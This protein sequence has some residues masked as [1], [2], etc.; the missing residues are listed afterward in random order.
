MAS[1]EGDATGYGGA[2]PAYG[3]YGA[4]GYGAAGYGGYG[5]YP[6]Q[7]APQAYGGYN[8][9]GYAQQYAAPQAAYGGYGGYGGADPYGAAGPPSAHLARAAMPFDFQIQRH[10]WVREQSLF[11][12]LALCHPGLHVAAKLMCAS[13]TH[14]CV[15]E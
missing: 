15:C 6:G 4:A 1:P 8:P 9:Y 12:C 2:R 7:A 10:I 14:V 3:G 11:V 13:G 5:G